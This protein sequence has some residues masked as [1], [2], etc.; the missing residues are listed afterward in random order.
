MILG[1][2]FL[3]ATTVICYFTDSTVASLPYVAT[4][5]DLAATISSI[6]LGYRIGKWTYDN[7]DEVIPRRMKWR[8]SRVDIYSLSLK[9]SISQGIACAYCIS[10]CVSL[11]L[12]GIVIQ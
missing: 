1:F 9:Y 7:M 3:K 5:V 2:L 10:N 12:L 4:F 6:V 11:F 8:I